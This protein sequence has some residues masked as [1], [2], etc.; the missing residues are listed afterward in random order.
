MSPIIINQT[1][2]TTSDSCSICCGSPGIRHM[3]HRLEMN[4]VSELVL[5]LDVDLHV[6]ASWSLTIRWTIERDIPRDL[7]IVP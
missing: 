2:A 7:A 1:V 5:P 3:V 6:T 4:E